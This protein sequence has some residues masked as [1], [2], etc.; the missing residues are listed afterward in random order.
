MCPPQGALRGIEVSKCP[1]LYFKVGSWF[2]PL[3]LKYQRMVFAT[4]EA[5]SQPTIRL[6][7]IQPHL[8]NP[9]E[10]QHQVPT[11]LLT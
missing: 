3:I 8:I 2:D 1:Q 5:S 9:Q 7:N 10:E 4:E 6:F 11:I